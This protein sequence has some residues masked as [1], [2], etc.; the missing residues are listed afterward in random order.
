MTLPLRWLR[1]L[2]WRRGWGGL[3]Q[4]VQRS[5]RNGSL[6]LWLAALFLLATFSYP[7][8]PQQGRVQDVLFVLDVSESMDVPDIQTPVVQAMHGQTRLSQAKALVAAM[9]ADLPCGSRTAVALFAGD[10]TVVL[11]EPLEVCAHYPAMEKVVSQLDTRMRWIGDSWV[12]RGLKSALDAAQQRQLQLVFVSDSDEMPHHS[13]PRVAELLPYKHKQQGMLVGVGGN[14][15]QPVPHRQPGGQIAGYWTP[16]EAVLEGNYPNLLAEVKALPAGGRLS[17]EAAAEVVEHQSQLNEALMQEMASALAIGYVR[18]DTVATTLSAFRQS[19]SGTQT[20]TAQ[21]ARWVL[22]A[23]A[24]MLI[25]L[26]WFWP[27][28]RA[29][30]RSVLGRG[31]FR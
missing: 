30:V 24:A 5:L 18:G 23:A 31:R 15:A 14:T 28:L 19:I 3:H 13:H 10:E 21:D 17:D 25:M 6:P 2:S 26:S 29:R 9:M 8:W 1:Q 16:E 20:T 27:L 7:Q 12:V 11:F 22:G 4:S